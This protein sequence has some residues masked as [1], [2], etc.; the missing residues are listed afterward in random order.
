MLAPGE[1]IELWVD[2]S[3]HPVGSETA[4]VSMPFDAGLMGGGMMGGGVMAN[5]QAL[6]NGH[7]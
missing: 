1:R 6:P 3:N 4:L 5:G 2:F 7:T